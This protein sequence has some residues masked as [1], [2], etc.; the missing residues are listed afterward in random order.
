MISHHPV[1]PIGYSLGD[2][3]PSLSSAASASSGLSPQ[4]SLGCTVKSVL[5]R[6]RHKWDTVTRVRLMGTKA[7]KEVPHE[8][9]NRH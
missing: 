3:G 9:V 4:V 6:E 1:P 8:T 2:R 5:R 7:H